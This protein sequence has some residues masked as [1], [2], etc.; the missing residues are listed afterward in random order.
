MPKNPG[1][2][3]LRGKAVHV[4]VLVAVGT[5]HESLAHARVALVE[6]RNQLGVLH[7]RHI[8]LVAGLAAE[9]FVAR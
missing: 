8:R 5:V 2:E 6:Q 4:L 9:R 3:E 1:V 7:V